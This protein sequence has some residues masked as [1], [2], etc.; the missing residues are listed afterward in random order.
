MNK[1]L[2]RLRQ[3]LK[4]LVGR[5]TTPDFPTLTSHAHRN[6]CDL[7]YFMDIDPRSPWHSKEFAAAFGG[8]NPPGEQ[9]D[10][11]SA[12]EGDRVRWDTLTLLL[13]EICVNRVPGAM[14]E[15]GVF[16][17][18]T[19]QLIHHY[20]PER[21]LYL[22]DTFSGFT[23]DDLASESLSIG[24]NQKQDF[25]ETSIEIVT[26]N[27]RPLNANV[28]FRPGWFPASVR[29]EDETERFALVHLDAD[30]ESPT[31]SGLAYFWPRLSP[32]GFLIVHDYNA[33]PGARMAVDR[34]RENAGASIVP[35]ADK[36]GTVIVAKPRA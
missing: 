11:S 3:S 34:F 21:R 29:P 19:A 27:I 30:L 8:F 12:P 31:E 7:Q 5:E 14:A 32:G 25:T 22:F 4:L 10:R 1:F 2:N 16:R 15:L 18:A 35:V 33:W 23:A 13:R 36:S 6:H 24:F 17:G 28:I 26:R 20:C 9:R